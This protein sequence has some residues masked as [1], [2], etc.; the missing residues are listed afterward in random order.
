MNVFVTGATGVLGR[1]TLPLLVRDGH[2]VHALARSDAN[3]ALI[4]EL[5]ATPVRADLFDSAAMRDAVRG[6][7]AVLHL[8][9]K[10][11]S[12]SKVGRRSAW[13]E[14][15]RIRTEG[16]RILADA[17]LDGGAS[18][19]VYP[20][21]TFLYPDCGDAWIDAAGTAP[22]PAWFLDS[23]LVAEAEVARFADGESRRGVTLRM[24]PFY[25]P[26][27]TQARELLALAR[28]GVG[29]VLGSPQAYEPLIWIADAAQAVVAAMLRAPSGVYDI[30][31]DEPLTR[32]EL[33][34]AIARAAGKRRLWRPPLWAVR[35]IAGDVARVNARSQRVSNRRFKA[36]TG[37]APA[38]PNGRVGWQRLTAGRA[39]DAPGQALPV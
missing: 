15:D 4:R 35:L 31:D 37:W 8:A 32:Q 13:R 2:T 12:S 24:G 25:G 22:A 19:F 34:A 21:V 23:T 30:V 1:A 10:I 27:S 18:V 29:M 26:T 36:A 5:G 3:E 38:V 28:K 9:S 14:N 11:P 17:A 20:S 7:D 39:V 6:H 33:T 16:T